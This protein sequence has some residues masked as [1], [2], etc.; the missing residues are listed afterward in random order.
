MNTLAS[1]K[2]PAALVIC[3]MLAS[4]DLLEKAD[5]VQFTTDFTLPDPFIVDENAD[6]PVNP[7]SSSNSS[8]QAERIRNT[9]STRIK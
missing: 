2:W 8:I 5:D 1:T 6:D 7:Y 4:C 9:R 3:L